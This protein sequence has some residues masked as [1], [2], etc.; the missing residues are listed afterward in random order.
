[1]NQMKKKYHHYQFVDMIYH[2]S[3]SQDL[4]ANNKE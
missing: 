3:F 4:I 1:M 2:D